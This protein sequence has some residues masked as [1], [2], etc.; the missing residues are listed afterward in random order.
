M[1]IIKQ[2][3]FLFLVFIISVYTY[4]YYSSPG[5]FEIGLN[6]A[7]ATEK[8]SESA[9]AR[10]DEKAEIK[11]GITKEF[12]A[13]DV[14][15]FHLSTY[16]NVDVKLEPAETNNVVINFVGHGT[17]YKNKGENLSD[18]FRVGL[19]NGTLKIE[20]FDRNKNMS[21][22]EF[23]KKFKDDEKGR[24]KMVVQVPEKFEFN[25][26]ELAGVTTDLIAKNMVFK[27][28]AV[29]TVSGDLQLK[30]SRGE[31]MEFATVSGDSVLEV[32][33][34]KDAEINSVSGDAKIQISNPKTKFSMSTVSGDLT[35]KLPKDSDVNVSFSSM[36][37]DLSNDFGASRKSTNTLKFS[38]LSGDAKVQKIQ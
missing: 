35:F 24:F 25:E 13:K 6:Q 1:K 3:W 18:W 23:S 7:E 26:F 33:D 21:L 27:K 11:V 32:S 10:P 4:Q 15:S 30:E 5:S 2:P 28:L 38:S 31:K 16:Y 9:D 22:K 34:L 19:K 20:N 8:T 29:A 37:G 36:T 17:G 12:P 14:K